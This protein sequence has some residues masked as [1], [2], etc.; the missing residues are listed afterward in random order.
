MN[1]Q[2]CLDWNPIWKDMF[3]QFT[4][5]SY[6]NVQNAKLSLPR[7]GPWMIT[8][9]KFMKA[10]KYFWIYISKLIIHK[11]FLEIKLLFCI[12]KRLC[13]PSLFQHQR[14]QSLARWMISSVVIEHPSK[15][16]WLQKSALS[17]KKSLAKTSL[18]ITLELNISEKT[19][20]LIVKT[21]KGKS[22]VN[23]T[24]K[25]MKILLTQSSIFIVTNVTN[26]S[27]PNVQW[28]YMYRQC[29]QIQKET[30]STNV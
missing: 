14:A 30:W 2:W 26:D 9:K 7:S 12:G 4:K 29:I 8:S 1:V 20:Q 5:V 25:F 28:I 22:H 18:K 11:P 3:H 13:T 23:L 27:Y 21:V 24:W 10:L 17:V 16:Q 19:M 15:Q 6:I